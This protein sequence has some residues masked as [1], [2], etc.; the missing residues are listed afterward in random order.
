LSPLPFSHSLW[1]GHSLWSRIHF[2]HWSDVNAAAAYQRVNAGQNDLVRLS[3][4]LLIFGTI[5]AE[6]IFWE[7]SS[8]HY[9][10]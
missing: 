1:F 7:R 2:G 5:V 3:G 8:S 10:E 6:R 4:Q 9:R